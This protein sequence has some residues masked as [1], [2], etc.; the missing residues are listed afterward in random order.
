MHYCYKVKDK[1]EIPISTL[2]EDI[3]LPQWKIIK[4]INK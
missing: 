1:A 4:G 3:Y 2:E